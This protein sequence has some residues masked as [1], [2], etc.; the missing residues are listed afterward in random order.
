MRRIVAFAPSFAVAA[1]ALL[2]VA[3]G[4]SKSKKSSSPTTTEPAPT[5]TETFTGSFGLGGTSANPFTNTATGDVTFK[6]ADLQPLTT[7]TIGM[8]IGTYDATLSPPCTLYS[9]DTSVRLGDTLLSSGVA[10]GN[11]CVQLRDVGNIFPGNT[12]TYT[13]EVTHP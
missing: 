11:Y 8:G 7:L 4:C 13:V 6:L 5:V 3:G 12:V 2:L 9:E 10:A 1:L